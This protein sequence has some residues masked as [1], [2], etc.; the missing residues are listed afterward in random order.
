MRKAQNIVGLVLA[1]AVLCG[2][3]GLWLW[4]KPRTTV[5]VPTSADAPAKVVRTFAQALNDRDY[6]A[7]KSI[8]VGDQVGVDAKWW[9]LHGPRVE[10]L[11]ILHSDSAVEGARCHRPTASAW[12]K[13]V[14]VHTV[15]T[16]K[17][18][19]GATD[20]SEP[21]HER[22]TYYLVRN[23]GSERWRILDWAKG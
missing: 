15:A 2:V 14:E 13:C 19:K 3:L 16:L 21:D 4:G 11:R 1:I 20:D 8:V 9:D 5:P 12:K 17:H 22:W 6:S 10:D 18:V 7:A 23:D